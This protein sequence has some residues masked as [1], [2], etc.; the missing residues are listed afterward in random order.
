[1]DLFLISLQSFISSCEVLL[2]LVIPALSFIA[3]LNDGGGLNYV[4]KNKNRKGR[5]II[6]A[7]YVFI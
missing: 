1:M 6:G 4:V 5:E 2:L 3:L 7:Y